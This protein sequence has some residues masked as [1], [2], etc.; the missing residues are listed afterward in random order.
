VLQS[1]GQGYNIGAWYYTAWNASNNLQ[2]LNSISVYGTRDP[3]GGVREY[4]EGADPWGL[5]TDYSNREPLLGFYDLLN[6]QVMDSHIRQAASSGLSF[7]AFYWYWNTDLN[8]EDPARS[9]GPLQ[10]LLSSSLKSQFRFLIAPIAKGS[11]PM[12]LSMW[13]NSVVPFMV[14]RYLSE[15]SYLKTIDGRP[16]IVLFDLRFTNA[17]DERRAVSFLR[18]A[19]LSRTRKD[20]VVLPRFEGQTPIQLASVQTNLQTDGFADFQLGP[21]APAEPYTETLSRWRSF[22]DQQAGFFHFVCASTGLDARP[23]WKVSWG[24][25]TYPNVDGVPYNTNITLEAFSNHL[26]VVKA[27]LDANPVETSKTLI[28]YAWNEWGEGGIIEPSRVNG[29]RYLDTVKAVFGLSPTLSRQPTRLNVMSRTNGILMLQ[30]TNLTVGITNVI[31]RNLDGEL[32]NGW[33]QVFAFVPTGPATNW[34]YNIGFT[35]PATFFRV[36]S[37]K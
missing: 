36:R 16:V 30:I 18:T 25:P 3:W 5:H 33:Q 35:T 14:T 12:T 22:T 31:E 23:W 34:S 11:A 21:S 29:Y 28:I 10:R 15:P 2:A 8:R 17:L 19:T 26:G 4:A 27:Y 20:P 13:S 9:V 24:P 37:L 32:T 7:F 6:Q 1:A